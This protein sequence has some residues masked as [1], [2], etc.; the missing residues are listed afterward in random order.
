[1]VCNFWATWCPPCREEIP[2]LIALSKK[3]EPKGVEVVGIAVDYAAK[4]RDFVKDYKVTYPVLVAGPDGLD[5]M[6]AAGNEVGGLPYTAFLDRQGKIVHEKL[7]ALSQ[8]EVD[9][10][11]G[12]M[13]RS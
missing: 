7:G 12:R 3:M 2:M 5:L 1:M 8:A 10:Q 11:L 6:R 4:V 9:G 13:L